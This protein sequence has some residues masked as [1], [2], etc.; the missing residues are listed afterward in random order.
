MVST[1]WEKQ[2]RNACGVDE[3]VPHLRYALQKGWLFSGGNS[4]IGRIFYTKM[5]DRDIASSVSIVE[6]EVVITHPFHPHY[7]YK[8]AEYNLKKM[9][10]K[11][12][13]VYQYDGNRCVIPIEHTSL[14]QESDIFM[15]F[16][17]GRAFF[18]FIDLLKI[19]EI[20]DELSGCSGENR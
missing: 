8:F 6:E 4:G 18:R 20:I 10:L 11:Q 5:D 9:Q 3:I 14:Y 17:G 1:F 15:H 19:R 12:F 16:S 7:L 13:I 2:S